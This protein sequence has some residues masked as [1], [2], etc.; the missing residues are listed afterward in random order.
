MTHWQE[1]TLKRV[2]FVLLHNIEEELTDELICL[3]SLGFFLKN[4]LR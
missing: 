3:I 4:D 1:D 2:Y